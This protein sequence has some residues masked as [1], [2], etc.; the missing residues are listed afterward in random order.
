M[1]R[2]SIRFF[3]SHTQRPEKPMGG[4]NL[5]GRPYSGR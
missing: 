4:A 1:K 3:H 2:A 5:V